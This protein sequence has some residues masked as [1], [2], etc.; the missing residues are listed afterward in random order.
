MQLKEV[1][2]E[3]NTK[4][5]YKKLIFYLL[6]HITHGPDFTKI[7]GRDAVIFLYKPTINVLKC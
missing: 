7:K 3:N 6:N 5:G 2:R 1:I 4:Q